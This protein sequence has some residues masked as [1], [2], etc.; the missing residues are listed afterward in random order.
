MAYTGAAGMDALPAAG[1]HPAAFGKRQQAA[2]SSAIAA[3]PAATA[4]RATAGD[5]TGRPKPMTRLAMYRS[6]SDAVGSWQWSGAA[7]VACDP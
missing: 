3:A 1:G 2:G 6:D 7:S 4:E 5:S